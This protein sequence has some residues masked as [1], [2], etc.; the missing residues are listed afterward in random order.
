MQPLGRHYLFREVD[1]GTHEVWKVLG[2]GFQGQ[3]DHVLRQAVSHEEK[4][5]R[6]RK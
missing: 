1:T 5:R 2:G 4:G 6:E 3:V